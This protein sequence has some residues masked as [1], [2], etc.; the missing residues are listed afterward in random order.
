MP[1]SN[2]Q[3]G[4]LSGRKL[5]ATLWELRQISFAGLDVSSKITS[6]DTFQIYA[7]NT[8]SI[9][10]NLQSPTCPPSPGSKVQR[11]STM[12]CM[13]E[14]GKEEPA[15]SLSYLED[16][17]VPCANGASTTSNELFKVLNRVWTLEEQHKSSVLEVNS[18]KA[19][20][21]MAWLQVKELTAQQIS[22]KQDLENL[23]NKFINERIEWQQAEQ[24]R[25]KTVQ[26]LQKK[27][28]DETMEKNEL[29]LLYRKVTKEL[30]DV[31]ELLMKTLQ[32]LDRERKARELM[33]D[34]CDAL[35]KEMGEEK[36]GLGASEL[37]KLFEEEERRQIKLT[38]DEF[39]DHENNTALNNLQAKLDRFLKTNRDFDAFEGLAGSI[40]ENPEFDSTEIQFTQDVKQ[41]FPSLD[42]HT[43][44]WTC[45]VNNERHIP[46]KAFEEVQTNGKLSEPEL[47]QN[48]SDIIVIESETEGDGND[49]EH[50][51]FYN[52]IYSM[53]M[54]QTDINGINTRN[55][56]ANV[57]CPIIECELN[58]ADNTDKSNAINEVQPLFVGCGI[59]EIYKQGAPNAIICRGL[60]K[61]PKDDKD[62]V[63]QWSCDYDL[64]WNEDN[65]PLDLVKGKTSRK[66]KKGAS[67]NEPQKDMK[68]K[69]NFTLALQEQDGQTYE[70]NNNVG[71]KQCFLPTKIVPDPG[72]PYRISAQYATKQNHEVITNIDINIKQSDSP[73]S[74]NSIDKGVW[75]F[76]NL[77]D[78]TR[79]SKSAHGSS[80][81]SP[82]QRW[83][84]TMSV[85]E[86]TFQTNENLTP[87]NLN[88]N[89]GKAC[90]IRT[91][92]Q[93]KR[94]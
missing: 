93:A 46:R 94:R 28:Q 60:S 82:T 90:A 58:H 45:T 10:C 61:M 12:R 48:A 2:P 29:N 59:N 88:S 50:N 69:A 55:S 15:K 83:V 1:S 89:P 39:E 52:R 91:P 33:E 67:L 11:G 16:K 18:L 6:N 42:F 19:E 8:P 85:S 30:T 34:I 38:E 41:S 21:E 70:Q 77:G 68:G 27:L 32:D 5:A 54:A 4:G 63:K 17:S 72:P 7:A 80:A 81:E 75:R 25:V 56:I 79:D 3:L 71:G 31:K 40:K 57:H 74:I 66:G 84:Y 23:T 87:D 37:T 13:S 36:A 22:H 76:Q 26:A 35:T 24:E 53:E 20:L 65:V 73:S 47:L 49:T 51:E 62:K 86:D 44:K 14:G 43:L 9:R 78:F 92:K 64:S